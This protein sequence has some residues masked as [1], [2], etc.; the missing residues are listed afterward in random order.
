[1]SKEALETIVAP[2]PGK[3]ISIDVKV[4]QIVKPNDRILTLEAMKME[5]EITCDVGGEVIEVLVSE[6]NFVNAQEVM[7]VI[8]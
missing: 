8:G 3:V 5:N 4:G 1:M 2:I 6:G 7:V